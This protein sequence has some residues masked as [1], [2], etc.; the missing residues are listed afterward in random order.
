MRDEQE[1]ADLAWRLLSELAHK[2]PEAVRIL[3]GADQDEVAGWGVP[4]PAGI[5]RLIERT[6]GFGI[7]GAD[8]AEFYRLAPEHGLSAGGWAVGPPGSAHLV[9]QAG[10]DALF[11]DVDA[12][13]GEWGRLFAATGH[14]AETWAYVAPSLSDWIAGLARAGLSMLGTGDEEALLERLGEAAH[15]VSYRP[16]L[17][18]TPVL[19]ARARAGGDPELAGVLAALPDEALVVDL[20]EVAAPVTLHLPCP[21]GLRGGYIEFQRRRGGRFAVGFPRF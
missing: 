15:V 11:V 4:L 10:G 8:S 5:R 13:T 1:R 2:A 16:D 7:G 9:H 21:T 3:P 14:F 17:L 18:G 12:T 20:R 6:R 19:R